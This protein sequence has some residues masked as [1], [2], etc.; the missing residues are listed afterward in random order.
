M[1]W[2]LLII[3]VPYIFIL[4]RYR[5][6]LAAITPYLPENSPDRFVSVVVA[7]KNEEDNLPGLLYDMSKQDYNDGCFEL[8]IVDDHS[9]DKTVE[10]ATEYKGISNLKVIGNE[11]SGKKQAVRTGVSVSS[12]EYIITTDA[13]CRMNKSW[14]RI[15]VSFCTCNKAD[16][17]ICPVSLEKRKGL[18]HHFQELEYLSL[19]GITAAAALAGNPVM[20]NG[21]N[22][23]FAKEAYLKHSHELHD[24]I[25]SG[26][27][28]FL[29]HSLKRETGNKILWLESKLAGVTTRSCTDLY[30]FLRQRARW[31]SK[32]GAYKDSAT[33]MLALVIFFT[34]LSQAVMTAVCFF[35]PALIPVTVACFSL[36]AL[37]DCLILINTAKRY[38]NLRIMDMFIPGEI[39]YPLYVL[40]VIFYLLY[41]KLIRRFSYPSQ[42][43][44]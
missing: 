37:P 25:G 36:K 39:L 23:A 43:G 3:I 41:P 32:A 29:L 18:F 42:K 10:I 6:K 40:S 11:G 1:Q 9:S 7:C 24:E 12:G 13:D 35:D 22:L 44:I 27:D 21:A 19:Q 16:L 2:L 4:L 31:L 17:V 33:R 8:I 20:C 26:D 5:L 15:I 28:V 30:A 34:I 38:E 14:L